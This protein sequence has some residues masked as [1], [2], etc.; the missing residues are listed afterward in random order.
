MQDASAVEVFEAGDDLSE[1]I[2]DF[3]FRECVSRFPNVGQRLQRQSGASCQVTHTQ[4]HTHERK[5]SML[6]TE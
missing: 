1:V 3:W 4:T 6:Q 5:R 2:A